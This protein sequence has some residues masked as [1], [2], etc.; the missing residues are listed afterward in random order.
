M[1]VTHGLYPPEELEKVRQAFA[2]RVADEDEAPARLSTAREELRRGGRRAGWVAE[3]AALRAEV[4]RAP[5]CAR[6]PS[7][8]RSAT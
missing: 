8:P 1:V 6:V 3:I 4:E 7:R 5:R 2:N